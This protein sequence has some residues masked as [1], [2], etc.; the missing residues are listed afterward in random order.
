M[1]GQG[2][3]LFIELRDKN[4]LAYSVSPLRMEGLDAGY[5]GAYIGCTPD[6]APKALEMMRVEFSKLCDKK[7]GEEELLRSQ[8]YL[9]GRHDLDLQ[10]VSS[11]AASILYDDI[12]GIPFDQTF[13]LAEKY[14]SVTA[15]EIQTVARKI[16]S[17]KSVISLVGPVDNIKHNK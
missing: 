12:Y 5:F 4:S 16:F 11:L 10:R 1:S 3:R 8:K 17:G 9:T 14:F 6:K 15:E 2:G 7:I 13:H